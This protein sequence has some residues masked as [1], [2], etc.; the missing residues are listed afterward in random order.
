MIVSRIGYRLRQFW[1]ALYAEPSGGDLEKISSLLTPAQMALFRQMH[2]S[3]QA[4]SI[5]VMRA[6]SQAS[7]GIP[8]EACRDLLRAALLHDVGKSRFPVRIWERAVIVLCKAY[9]P[10][11]VRLWGDGA[12]EGGALGWRRA[13]VVAQQHATWGAQMAEEAGASPLAAALIRR[14]Q[15]QAPN[16]GGDLEDRLLQLLQAADHEL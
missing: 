4:H 2:R 15:D 10:G 7:Q 1:S 8:D 11:K 14:H 12:A 16:P 3:E 6:V 9:L 13:F 5:Q